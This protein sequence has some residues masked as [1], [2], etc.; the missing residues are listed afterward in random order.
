[1]EKEGEIK[2][3]KEKKNMEHRKA[4]VKKHSI[5]NCKK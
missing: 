2:Q 1:M 5:K 3:V 4:D